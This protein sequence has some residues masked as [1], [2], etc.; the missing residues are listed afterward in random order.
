MLW[1]IPTCYPCRFLS[2][3]LAQILPQWKARDR[4]WP[5]FFSPRCLY[6]HDFRVRT[7][8]E[9]LKLEKTLKITSS[10]HPPGAITA[11]PVYRTTSQST[12]STS[13]GMGQPVPGPLCFF[14]LKNHPNIQLCPP[15]PVQTEAV[16]SHLI[17]PSHFQPL[18]PFL[19]LHL[20]ERTRSASLDTH[21][22]RRHLSFLDRKRGRAAHGTEALEHGSCPPYCSRR[23]C[24]GAPRSEPACVCSGWRTARSSSRTPSTARGTRESEKAQNGMA[25]KSYY[26]WGWGGDV[27]LLHTQTRL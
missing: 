4:S 3:E 1:S 15:P 26:I 24:R 8:M 9:T 25:G 2:R 19:P 13:S 6:K 27:I 23:I 10:N 5:C 17:Q 21:L 7:C 20:P 16:S 22:T 12:T 11:K 18:H 14:H